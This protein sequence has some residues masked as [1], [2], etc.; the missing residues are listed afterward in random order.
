[1]VG[2]DVLQGELKRG[3]SE[4]VRYGGVGMPNSGTKL[5]FS[6]RNSLGILQLHDNELSHGL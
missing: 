2:E 4:T 5:M 1:M 3:L 6:S